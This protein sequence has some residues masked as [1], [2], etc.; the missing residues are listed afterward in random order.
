MLQPRNTQPSQLWPGLL[1]ALL[2][3]PACSRQ[4]DGLGT[5]DLAKERPNLLI[6]S[7]DTLRADA[8][9]CYGN[10]QETSPNIDA[11][12]GS[13]V[14]FEQ[15]TSTTSWTLPAHISM[16]TGLNI[17][18]HGICDERLWEAVGMPGGP[19]ELPLRGEFV[20][21]PLYRAGY[22][23]AGFFT[24]KY[25]DSD[26]GFGQG[27]QEWRRIGNT[28]W[29]DPE[30]KAKYDA[31][32]KSGATDELKQWTASNPEQFDS[33]APN[34]KGVVDA[35]LEWLDQEDGEP[36]FLFMHL[37]DVHDEYVAPEP[38]T[39]RF[40]PDYSGP[41]DGTE[42]S[43]ALSK[44]NSRMPARDLQNLRARYL[45]EVAWVDSQI[46][47]L[48]AELDKRGLRENTVVVLTSDHGE[49]FFEHGNKTHRTQLFPESI[50][51]PLIFSWPGHIDAGRR[52]AEP[53]GIID[54]APTV[55]ALL[56]VPPPAS[57]SGRDLSVALKGQDRLPPFPY[58]TELQLF[59]RGNMTPIR[60]TGLR[61]GDELFLRVVKRDGSESGV[62]FDLAK[63]P[64]GKGPGEPLDPAGFAR[65]DELLDEVRINTLTERELAPNRADLYQR[66][67]KVVGDEL[68]G[69][70]YLESDGDKPVT[71][72]SKLC[73]DGCFAAPPKEAK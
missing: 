31:L 68:A 30:L 60:H 2:L 21:E 41:V 17:S 12:A 26:F 16:L 22:R 64:T 19:A 63:N 34:T 43:S 73:I 35:S 57:V 33:Q 53:V 32:V 72:S 23:T 61:L 18:A 13:G 20:S 44:V 8:L 71:T 58:L 66:L 14:L 52:V 6:I 67:G 28:V 1:A 59:Q 42:V 54:I 45:G 24:W 25:L 10:Q 69:M 5:S 65:F 62:R 56:D 46:G 37:F 70:G 29:S 50:Q 4:T 27:F 48:L 38:F 15:T 36:F 3:L 51:V 40:D 7:I 39:T 11:L 47:R 9:S 49:E 55:S